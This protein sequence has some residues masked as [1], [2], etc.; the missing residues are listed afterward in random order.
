[1]FRAILSERPG[2]SAAIGNS[3]QVIVLSDDDDE[4]IVPS[5]PRLSGRP[6][7][8]RRA[9]SDVSEDSDSVRSRSDIGRAE[10]DRSD[11]DGSDRSDDDDS[12]RSSGSGSGSGS[13]SSVQVCP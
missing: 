7:C 13:A 6:R 1:M 5:P 4:I 10:S 9:Y 3:P 2:A 12:D 11:D 8:N